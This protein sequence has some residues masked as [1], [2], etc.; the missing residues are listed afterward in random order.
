M[1]LRAKFERDEAKPAPPPKPKPI[2]TPAARNLALA[3]K[4]A[5]LIDDGTIR[6]YSEAARLLGVSQPRVTHLMALLLLAPEIQER[7]LL[8]QIAPGDK[9]L[10]RAARHV[11]W[12]EQVAALDSA[13]RPDCTSR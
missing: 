1:K 5:A 4:L 2:G 10:R 3:Y 11:G 7:I 13:N 12:S 8:E 6:D 9:V